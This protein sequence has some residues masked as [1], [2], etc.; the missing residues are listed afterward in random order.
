VCVGFAFE[1]P[2]FAELDN[3]RTKLGKGDDE[4]QLVTIAGHYAPNPGT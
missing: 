3:I 4:Q 2:H 1:D